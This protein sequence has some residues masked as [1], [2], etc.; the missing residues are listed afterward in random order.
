MTEL[1]AAT[2]RQDW[3]RL[4][5]EAHTLKGSLGT[6]CA[7]G[8]YAAALRLETLARNQS[9]TD[10]AEAF[11]SLITEID[12]LQLVLAELDPSALSGAPLA[13][14]PPEGERAG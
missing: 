2:A 10:L 5:R 14:S 1:A 9:P 13:P 12:R 7:G 6:L 4:A 3:T 11:Q 8:A